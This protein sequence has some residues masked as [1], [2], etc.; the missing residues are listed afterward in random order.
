MQ[1]LSLLATFM[2]SLGGSVCQGPALSQGPSMQSQD[3]SALL[4]RINQQRTYP[5]L[6]FAQEKLKTDPHDAEAHRTLVE[7]YGE[8]HGQFLNELRESW[9]AVRCNPDNPYDIM[10]LGSKLRYVDH[11]ESL[12]F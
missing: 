9:A 2:I 6:K 11:A 10:T 12:Y 3:Q 1:P 5:T 4:K 7:H 8:E